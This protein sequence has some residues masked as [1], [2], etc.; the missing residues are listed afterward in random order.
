MMVQGSLTSV[1]AV[2]G[3]LNSYFDPSR[4]IDRSGARALS[5]APYYKSSSNPSSRED[6]VWCTRYKV[7]PL[8]CKA[9]C[10]TG[11]NL[12]LTWVKG[13]RRIFCTRAIACV[14]LKPHT[15][16]RSAPYENNSDTE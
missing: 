3:F 11:L 10:V 7:L 1:R 6:L 2:K 16:E 9:I 8:A 15:C 5:L 12:A 13:R 14:T 4:F